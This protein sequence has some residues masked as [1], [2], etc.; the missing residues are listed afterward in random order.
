MAEMKVTLKSDSDK[1]M[2][3]K[4]AEMNL[5]LASEMNM[6]VAGMIDKV[7]RREMAEMSLS[8]AETIGG[9][10]VVEVGTTDEMKLSVAKMIPENECDSTRE[11]A[12]QLSK[13]STNLSSI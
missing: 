10:I 1:V 2:R 11:A 4:M 3:G 13:K 5:S 9:V 6:S 8:M 7:M 12:L